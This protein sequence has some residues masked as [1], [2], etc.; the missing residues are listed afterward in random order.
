MLGLAL[1]AAFPVV[2]QDAEDHRK[3][4]ER[5]TNGY[6]VTDTSKAFAEVAGV[7]AMEARVEIFDA[8]LTIRGCT[9]L[10]D[11]LVSGMNQAR[12]LE[13]TDVL[14]L[15]ANN[16]KRSEL[17]RLVCLRA[18][19]ITKAPVSAKHLL[20]K[21]F[22]KDPQ[23][24]QREWQ[25]TVGMV[26]AQGRLDAGN[27][28][29]LNKEVRALLS[30]AGTPWSIL[31]SK[32]FLSQE[33][34]SR[35]AEAMT[36]SKLPGDQAEA[37]RNLAAFTD[38]HPLWISEAKKLLLNA[39]CGPRVAVLEMAKT[40]SIH[41]LA[42]HL[43][44]ALEQEVQRG[45]RFVNDFAA[46]LRAITGRQFGTNPESWSRWWQR[47][48]DQFLK[49][50]APQVKQVDAT[51]KEERTVA[52]LFGIPVDS[53]RVAIV[54]DGSGSMNDLLDDRPC[55]QAAAEEMESFLERLSEK[56]YFQVVV[57]A[58]DQRACFKKSVLNSAKN[59]K[60]AVKYIRDFDYST[61][62]AM[63]DVLVEAQR[64]DMVDTMLFISDGGG[65]WG[66]YAFAGHMEPV[67]KQEYERTGVRIHSIF[68]GSSNTKRRFMQNL[69]DLTS[70]ILVAP[71][72]S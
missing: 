58:R 44:H 63:H 64:N 11:W 34:A 71:S 62:S 42:P 1:L 20:Q 13:E 57:I 67:L 40:H 60:A 8:K 6:E 69:A 23:D 17:L 53:L 35:V 33:D 16:K 3:L 37:T 61:A 4:L 12:T 46:T 59:R 36:R 24:I 45:G 26:H 19:Q 70:G 65:S 55:S 43:I 72:D 5:A 22:L 18:L 14:A 68:V 49:N 2:F 56:A 66:S 32:V 39:A 27:I 51:E 7:N 48:G 28:K 10:R 21:K 30:K 9:Q 38:Y 54:V 15:A 47:E 52:S 41:R 25:R 31:C 29:D 50:P